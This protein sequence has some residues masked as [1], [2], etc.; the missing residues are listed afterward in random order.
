MLKFLPELCPPTS[1]TSQLTLTEEPL[2]A[3]A[4]F[5][6]PAYAPEL[7]MA[8]THALQISQ[9]NH[10]ESPG[11]SSSR[12]WRSRRIDSDDPAQR[13]GN[14]AGEFLTTRLAKATS[15]VVVSPAKSGELVNSGLPAPFAQMTCRSAIDRDRQAKCRVP[16]EN[17]PLLHR[18]R[19]FHALE[20]P[21][22]KR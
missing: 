20:Q 15:I 4:L 22:S 11:V 19:R 2:R 14:N 17:P 9:M 21:G 13:I 1:R 12:R 10:N 5:Q 6:V 7:T 16:P 3:G 18:S 8:S